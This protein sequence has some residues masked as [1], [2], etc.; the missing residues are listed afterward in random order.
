MGLQYLVDS[1][2]LDQ[3]MWINWQRLNTASQRERLDAGYRASIALGGPLR[4]LGHWHVVH[5]GGQQFQ[6]GPVSDSQGA[7]LGLEW[8]AP[9]GR[10]R[11]TVDAHVVGTRHAPDRELPDATE[12]GL[13]VFGRG[14]LEWADWRAHAVVW[15]S[16]DAR[17]TEGDANY[18]SLQQDGRVHRV[19]DYAELGIT[20]H[21][22]PAEGVHMFAAFRVHR[23][24][25]HYEYSYRI[26]ARVRVRRIL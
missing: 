20:R 12:G 11:A 3:D 5:E 4:L 24:E 18:L 14:A 13:G 25:S 2:R 16:R 26:V 15:R 1:R 7:A 10:T 8:A 21:F 23:V 9:L 6:Q 22:R 19:R 17:K